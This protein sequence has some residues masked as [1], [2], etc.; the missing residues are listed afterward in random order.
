MLHNVDRAEADI[1]IEPRKYFGYYERAESASPS[2]AQTLQRLQ[3]RHYQSRLELLQA[4]FE[5]R[6]GGRKARAEPEQPIFPSNTAR[7]SSPPGPATAALNAIFT[8]A[9]ST[10]VSHPT[11]HAGQ[12][13]ALQQ[14]NA[15]FQNS[16]YGFESPQTN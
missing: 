5:E 8:P 7:A 15:S 2:W 1:A 13:E 11:A 3:P 14:V 10:P 12:N 4:E 6:N 9:P 16:N